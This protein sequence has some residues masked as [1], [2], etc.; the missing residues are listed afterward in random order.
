MLCK[1]FDD[2]VIIQVGVLVLKQIKQN[3]NDDSCYCF[4][5]YVVNGYVSYDIKYNV[6]IVFVSCL[7]QYSLNYSLSLQGSLVWMEKNV[8]VGKGI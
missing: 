3:K 5:D 2:S 7:L 4:D 6:G 8:Y 1:S